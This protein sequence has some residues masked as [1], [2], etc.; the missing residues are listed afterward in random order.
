MQIVTKLLDH[1]CIGETTPA[2]TA[3]VLAKELKDK[4]KKF[5]SFAEAPF[6]TGEVVIFETAE[7]IID[8]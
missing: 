4:S 6:Q 3:G 2:P 7:D 1:L 5:K 8:C